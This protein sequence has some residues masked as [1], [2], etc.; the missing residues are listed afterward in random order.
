MLEQDIVN[1]YS[2]VFKDEGKLEGQL[3]LELD[4]SVQPVQLSLRRV[5][6]AIKDKLQAELERLSNMEIITKVD[7]PINWIS[8]LVVTTKRNGKDPVYVDPKPLNNALKR[9]HYPL[10][11]NE[12]VLPLL[13]NAKLF[14]ALDARNRFW[15]VQL[16]TDS[17]YLITFSTP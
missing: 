13:S 5:P 2:D 1:S 7:D 15:H 3:H 12:D 16:D 4:E 14:T 17:S 9:N 11:T 8:S 10:P 6:L